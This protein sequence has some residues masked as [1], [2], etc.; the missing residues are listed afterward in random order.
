MQA[1]LL[2]CAG[3]AL[4]SAALAAGTQGA[5][6]RA[7]MLVTGTITES[8][9]GGVVSYA[10]DHPE[11]LP[12]AV[13]GL[14][15][16]AIPTWKFDAAT[17]GAGTAAKTPMA[18]RVVA[19]TLAADKIQLQIEGV[20]FG[21]PD[22]HPGIAVVKKAHPMYPPAAARALVRGTVYVAMR[23]DAAAR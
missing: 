2:F 9:D 4:S 11:E 13:K 7:S 10:I 16:S 19:T 22:G 3:L 15:T 1:W 21:A 23:V 17:V 18:V 12:P 5:P 20:H 14:L 6:V 8:P